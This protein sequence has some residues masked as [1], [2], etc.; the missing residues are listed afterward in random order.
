MYV[1]IRMYMYVYVC[2]CIYVYIYMCVCVCIY[3][4]ICMCMYVCVCIYKYV[5]MYVCNVCTYVYNVCSVYL[6][7]PQDKASHYVWPVYATIKVCNKLFALRECGYRHPP[8]S[9]RPMTCSA[10]GS[11][12]LIHL[13]WIFSWQCS[14]W[15]RRRVAGHWSATVTMAASCSIIVALGLSLYH[16]ELA[17]S[18]RLVM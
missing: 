18:R 4:C 2:M 6:L 14:H 3:V 5:C 12:S 1:Y 11:H 8:P 16:S 9:S 13:A 7:L 15:R 17:A 10:G